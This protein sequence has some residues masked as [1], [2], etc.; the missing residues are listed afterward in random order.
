VQLA[1]CLVGLCLCRSVI[2]Q[3]RETWKGQP[4]EVRWLAVSPDSKTLASCT[5]NGNDA[6]LWDLAG[7][8]KAA[9]VVSDQMAAV[10]AAVFTSDGKSL[11]TIGRRA[12]KEAAPKDSIVGSAQVWDLAT[13]KVQLTIDY[14]EGFGSGLITPDGKSLITVAWKTG[15]VIVYDLN[16][17]KPAEPFELDKYYRDLC[18]AALSPDGKT[19]AVGARDGGIL[20]WDLE[21]KGKR[22]TIP[23]DKIR[24]ASVKVLAFS[25]D[26]KTLASGD[27]YY[28]VVCLWDARNGDA[29]GKLDFHPRVMAVKAIA[30]SPDGKTVA[31]GGRPW[32]VS[33]WDLAAGGERDDFEGDLRT[34]DVYCAVFTP[35]G[36]TL[37]TGGMDQDKAIW[38][39]DVPQGK[40]AGVKPFAELTPSERDAQ[41]TFYQDNAKPRAP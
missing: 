13:Q 24:P 16:S 10:G 35:D 28:G 38:F 2:A 23:P 14:H 22:A 34:N 20:L 5:L 6:R 9:T 8:K 27:G 32:G 36:K 17:G 33:L 1:V 26:S 7:G 29:A 4:Q 30:F 25:P 37:I 19:L 11:V 15:Q 41:K 21:K 3:P 18:S 12:A 40:A 31:V 39:W